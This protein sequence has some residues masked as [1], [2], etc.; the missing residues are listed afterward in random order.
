MI[1]RPEYGPA[2]PFHQADGMKEKG[3][4]VPGYMAFKSKYPCS[5]PL[6]F[7]KHSSLLPNLN[8]LALCTYLPTAINIFIHI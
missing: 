5:S 4:F 2:G 7:S 3:A 8:D 6:I 1:F